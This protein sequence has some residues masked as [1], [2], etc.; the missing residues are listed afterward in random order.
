MM[1]EI[2]RFHLRHFLEGGWTEDAGV[3][4][5][6]IDMVDVVGRKALDGFE[7]VSVGC[8]FDF[9]YD[10]STSLGFRKVI[11][12][13]GGGRGWITDGTDDGRIW[14]GKVLLDQ[15]VADAWSGSWIS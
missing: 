10:D 8:T 13:F 6:D 4:D 5:D 9:D 3:R 15:A 1:Q 2:R 14:K 12:V 11:E 7:G